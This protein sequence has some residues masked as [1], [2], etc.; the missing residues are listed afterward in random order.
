MTKNQLARIG[1][2]LAGI[3]GEPVEVED[4]KGVVYVFGSEL[5]TLRL[6]LQ[7]RNN[8][9]ARVGYSQNFHSHYFSLELNFVGQND[10]CATEKVAG[11]ENKMECERAIDALVTEYNAISQCQIK[12][13]LTDEGY[14]LE[15]IGHVDE[16]FKISGDREYLS[17]RIQLMI[18]ENT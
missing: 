12:V 10:S 6:L 18:E 7:Y 3:A 14:C 13:S 5:A 17:K 1:K 11:Q 15:T 16:D 9:Q 8:N 4:I 2:D